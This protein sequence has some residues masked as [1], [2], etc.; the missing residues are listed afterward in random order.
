MR[1]VFRVGSGG[2]DIA[3]HALARQVAI[4]RKNFVVDACRHALEVLRGLQI[5][6][7]KQNASMGVQ[8][9][10]DVFAVVARPIRQIHLIGS[11]FHDQRQWLVRRHLA[12]ADGIEMSQVHG[13]AANCSE[14]LARRS[15]SAFHIVHLKSR[16]C[17]SC[18]S[19]APCF[20]LR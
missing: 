9:L 14:T 16:S 5:E 12:L 1:L 8:L 2:V 3:P 17:D 18:G 13:F 15:H 11:G 10:R 20:A 6:P 4:F 7:A 19:E